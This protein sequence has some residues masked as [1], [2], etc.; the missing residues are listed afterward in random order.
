MKLFVARQLIHSC[1]QPV[2][3][4]ER[5]ARPGGMDHVVGQQIEL[6]A[7]LLGQLV[8]PLLGQRARSHDQASLHIPPEH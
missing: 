6:E 2:A 5:V 4:L 7:E 8:L 3:L 1:N